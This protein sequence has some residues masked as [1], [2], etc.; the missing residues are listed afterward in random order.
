M[1]DM[2]GTALL[3]AVVAMT[4]CAAGLCETSC[5]MFVCISG[6]LGRSWA[7]CMSP[8]GKPY[9]HYF[10]LSNAAII[11]LFPFGLSSVVCYIERVPIPHGA[12]G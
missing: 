7:V 2:G 12:N 10:Y 9:Q 8:V 4:R 5:F 11:E 1:H 3:V 6:G